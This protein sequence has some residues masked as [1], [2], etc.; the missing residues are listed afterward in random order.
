M[1]NF[2]HLKKLMEFFGDLEVNYI[3]KFYDLKIL[4]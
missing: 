3:K 4:M 1:A 2:M